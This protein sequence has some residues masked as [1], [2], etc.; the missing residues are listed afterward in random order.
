MKF[1]LVILNGQVEAHLCILLR[2]LKLKTLVIRHTLL[3]MTGFIK[4]Y[5]FYISC[6]VSNRTVSVS[7]AVKAEFPLFLQNKIEIIH[8]WV[9]CNDLSNQKKSLTDFNLN[10][11]K[12]LKIYYIGRLDPGKNIEE[13]IL[14][15]KDIE[16]LELNI[17]G[18]GP[19]LDSLKKNIHLG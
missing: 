7:Q 12:K 11:E 17:V 10:N 18:N 8:N 19:Q 16:N 4:R 13:L 14:A 1:D 5:M 15:C 6:L 3:S 2:L 9:E